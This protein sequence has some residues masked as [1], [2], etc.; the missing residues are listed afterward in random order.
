MGIYRRPPAERI[1]TALS[2]ESFRRLWRCLDSL[3]RRGKTQ[4][5]VDNS[6]F[7]EKHVASPG[8]PF[9][10]CLRNGLFY[11]R[12]FG[13]RCYI[14]L[15]LNDRP[16]EFYGISPRQD[17]MDPWFDRC[18]ICSACQIFCPGKANYGRGNEQLP[19]CVLSDPEKRAVDRS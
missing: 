1:I 19:L 14:G 17:G 9:G 3:T 5:Y 4:A 8:G 10:R 2:G 18:K 15:I 11:S 7:S 13:S 16:P 12:K 6:P